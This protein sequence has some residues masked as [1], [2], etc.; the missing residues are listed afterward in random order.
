MDANSRLGSTT[1]AAIGPHQADDENVKGGFLHNWLLQHDLFLPQTFDTCHD[2]D[3]AT[4]THPAGTTARLDFVAVPS[5][6]DVQQ[7]RT[8]I[9]PDID[10]TLHR[11]DHACV[12]ADVRLTCHVADR[13]PRGERLCSVH[14]PD[15]AF[16]W[17]ADVHTHAAA[18]Q[19]WL[20]QQSVPQRH[21]RKSHLSNSTKQL[22][23]AK[24]FHWKR[25]GEI[26]RHH[27]RSLLRLLFDAWQ[28]PLHLSPDV[29]PWVRQCDHLEAWHSWAYSDLAA[30]VV[31]AI[32]E[33]DRVFYEDLAVQSGAAAEHG[34]AA[35]WASIRHVLPRWRNKRK[36][37]L[38]CVGPSLHDQFQHYDD[39]EAGHP[40]EYGEL[41]AECHASQKDSVADLPL[42]VNLCDIPSRMDIEALGCKLATN[43]AAG[44]D[45]VAPAIL[46]QACAH[47]SSWLHPLFL[48]M[49]VLGVEPLQGKGG[50]LH[51]ISKKEA[52]RRIDQ[53]RGIMLIDS[54]A[55]LAHSFLRR[56][57]L[58][59]LH[60]LRQPLQL[61]GFAIYIGVLPCLRRPTFGP[62]LNVLR[63]VGCPLQLSSSIFGVHFTRW[64]GK[65]C[66]A[67]RRPCIPSS[68]PCLRVKRLI[69]RPLLIGHRTP[70]T[71]L[72]S[73]YQNVLHVSFVMPIDIHGIHW[74]LQIVFIRQTERGS[75]PGS[76][77]ADV[78]FNGLMALLLDELQQ[79]L[80]A[81]GP[82]TMAYAQLGHR[83][84]PVAWVD[85][86]ALPVVSLAGRSSRFSHSV[87]P[88][89]RD[90]G[91]CLFWTPA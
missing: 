13:R 76:P 52:S 15:Q 28:Q 25:L 12:C 54:I 85:D 67:H 56:Q 1:S 29:R 86:V 37:N 63:P 77:L 91:L 75:R 68:W 31:P 7:V 24:K 61:G 26:R 39:L 27:R 40:V 49:W 83:A 23:L 90:R 88:R 66:W 5:N 47:F 9:H 60:R 2:G 8:W 78:A 48:K 46:Q 11:P 41:L 74:V 35:L 53:M 89:H 43:K 30:R 6:I 59:V 51:A 65:S 10:L 69:C 45:A 32:R 17:A 87:D 58:P 79:R 57:F 18:L 82:M 62:S 22:I 4:W 64:S 36:A 73:A 55:K 19:A 70:Q 34:H 81:S 84:L 14:V 3:G 38:R 71:L 50:L 80:D 20:Q 44:I 21:W 42:T 72:N 33:D 16:S